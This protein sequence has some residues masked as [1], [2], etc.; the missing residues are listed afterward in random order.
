MPF[1]ARAPKR[2]KRPRELGLSGGAPMV[3]MKV[4]ALI[5]SSG[6]ERYFSL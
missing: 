1:A 2:Q 6:T 3:E 5:S 4:I